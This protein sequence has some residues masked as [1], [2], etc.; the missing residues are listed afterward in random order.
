M[1]SKDP[2]TREIPFQPSTIETIDYAASNWLKDLG[3]HVDTNKGFKQI[4]I[5]WTAPERAYSVKKNKNVRDGSGSLIM[6]IMTI[7]R[8]S[9]EKDP[10]R[11]GGYSGNV[12]PNSDHKGGSIVVSRKIN[13]ERTSAYASADA[14]EKRKQFNFPRKN[15]KVVYQSVIMPMPVYI[16]VTYKVSIRCEYQQQINQATQPF[17]TRSGGINYFV[18]EHEKHR[19]EAFMQPDFTQ[20]SNVA[21]IGEEEQFYL[22]TF[23]VKVLGYLIGADKNQEQP[24]M[25]IREN[26][27]EVKIGRERVILGDEIGHADLNKSKAG[28]DGKYRG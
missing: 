3:I 17:I 14:K 8:T 23:E 6:P 18:I 7:E 15:P 12:P 20:E 21:E 25:V 24:K 2:N 26:A 11:K 4:P 19:Y 1:A 16:N 9:M 5:Q 27:V 22:T 13:Q 28:I 10:S